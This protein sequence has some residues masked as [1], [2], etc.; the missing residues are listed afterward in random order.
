M[1]VAIRSVVGAVCI[2]CSRHRRSGRGG[3]GGADPA[4]EPG[5]A[6]ADAQHD[7]RPS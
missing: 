1:A 2:I 7:E 5:Q 6:V 4:P 3:Q